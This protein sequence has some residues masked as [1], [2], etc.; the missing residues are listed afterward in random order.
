MFLFT[1]GRSNEMY[2]N[3]RNNTLAWTGKVG[4]IESSGVIFLPR[5]EVKVC[6]GFTSCGGNKL[7]DIEI[8]L[9]SLSL[10]L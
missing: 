1:F 2:N 8:Y 7:G 10:S 9:F 3:K 5:G 6:Q 4:E